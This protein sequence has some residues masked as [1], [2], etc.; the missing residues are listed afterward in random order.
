[1]FWFEVNHIL[2]VAPITRNCNGLHVRLEFI[3][4]FGRRVH[5]LATMGRKMGINSKAVEARERKETQKKLKNDA[6]E[7]QREDEFW[8]DDDKQINRKLNRQKEKE[9]K[10][11][12]ERDRKAANKAAYELEMQA[13]QAAKL[14]SAKGQVVKVSEPKVTRHEVQK[15]IEE[16]QKQITKQLK[17]VNLEPIQLVPN[18]NRLDDGENA[19]TIDQA[20]D[21]LKSSAK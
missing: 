5:V 8:R 13:A 7:R 4:R 12:E 16:E 10:A 3:D 2:Y 9:Q 20:L 11:Q 17:K 15:N 21:L 14:K 1:M 6:I 19:S 18:I